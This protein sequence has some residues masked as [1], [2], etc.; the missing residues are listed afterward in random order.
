M[1]HYLPEVN[2]LAVGYPAL[3]PSA[4]IGLRAEVA[5]VP[6]YEG[7]VVFTPRDLRPTEARANFEGLCR[8]DG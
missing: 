3:H 1:K 4:P 7:V 6:A 2:V 8:R 5:V